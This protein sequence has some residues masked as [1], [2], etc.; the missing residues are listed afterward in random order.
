MSLPTF[1]CGPCAQAFQPQPNDKNTR[2]IDEVTHQII[3]RALPDSVKVRHDAAHTSGVALRV[4]DH[5]GGFLFVIETEVGKQHQVFRK[6]FWHPSLGTGCIA[7][8]G[9]VLQPN[10]QEQDFARCAPHLKNLDP[11]TVR[12]F[13][14]DLCRVAHDHWIYMLNAVTRAQLACRSSV[15]VKFRDGRLSHIIISNEIR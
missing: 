2:R 3:Q 12:M 1:D 8:S 6:C 13:C 9:F 14:H 11:S 10:I 5:L 7:S 15:R 4:G